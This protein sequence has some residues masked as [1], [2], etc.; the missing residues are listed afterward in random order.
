M[1]KH[2]VIV[3]NYNYFDLISINRKVLEKKNNN[4]VR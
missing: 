3:Y 2:R 4:E 1:I